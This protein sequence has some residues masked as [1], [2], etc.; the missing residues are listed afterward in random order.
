[1]R[2]PQHTTGIPE[3]LPLEREEDSLDTKAETGGATTAV[4]PLT[5]WVAQKPERGKRLMRLSSFRAL[6]FVDEM[7]DG[8]MDQDVVGG[9]LPALPLPRVVV[10]QGQANVKFRQFSL[11][12]P[13]EPPVR[14]FTRPFHQPVSLVRSDTGTIRIVVHGRQLFGFRLVIFHPYTSATYG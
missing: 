4:R 1:M 14:A 10:L 9:G 2:R 3:L 5:P 6:S 13:H 7:L 8:R 12:S 11:Y